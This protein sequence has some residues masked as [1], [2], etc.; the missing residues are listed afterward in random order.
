MRDG[1]DNAITDWE[2]GMTAPA[3]G[4]AGAGQNLRGIPLPQR[5]R[6]RNDGILGNGERKSRQDAGATP[7]R[8]SYEVTDLGPNLERLEEERPELVNALRELVRQ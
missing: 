8:S 5:A 4:N 7:E 1:M 2:A 3:D 6:D